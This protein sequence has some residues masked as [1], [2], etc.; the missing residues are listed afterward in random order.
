MTRPEMHLTIKGST[1]FF[2]QLQHAKLSFTHFC[3]R[4]NTTHVFM[5]G[6]HVAKYH[7]KDCTFWDCGDSSTNTT[8][9]YNYYYDYDYVYGTSRRRRQIDTNDLYYEAY[10]DKVAGG[11]SNVKTWMYDGSTWEE[12]APMSITRDRP[13]CSLLNMPN[14]KVISYKIVTEI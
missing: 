9:D 13:A 4:I 5:G 1:L 12:I 2:E 8:D 10:E 14:G 7:F 3:L 6:G 11:I